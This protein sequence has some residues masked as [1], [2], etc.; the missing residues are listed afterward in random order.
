MEFP[1][2][3]NELDGVMTQLE[4][5]YRDMCDIEF[6]IEQGKL[7]M[8]QTR[9]GK[10]TA[11]AALKIAV[12]MVA[13][14]LINKEEAVLRVDP[15]QLDQLL[16]PQF[17]AVREARRSWRRASTPR[18]APPS[19]RSSS[20]PTT[21]RSTRRTGRK[22]IL[23][24]W[25]TTPDDLHGMIAAQGILT[26][27][28]ARRRHAA[29]VARGMGKP[30][31]VRRGGAQDR[32]GGQDARAWTAPSIHEGDIISIDGTAGIVVLGAVKLVPPKVS[33]EFGTVLGVGGRVPHDGRRRQRR[34]SRRRAAAAVRSAPR[35]SACAAPSTCSSATGSRSSRT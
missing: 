32:L 6:T 30:C 7:W 9:I 19:A 14:G 26:A 10:R 34:H 23:V 18:R 3:G 2:A 5:H 25:E 24:R 17:D 1:E 33:G 11:R 22:V 16:H 21:P 29:V 4:Q 27:T 28:A 13:E 12:D 31:V 15:E 8:L 35:A 20:P